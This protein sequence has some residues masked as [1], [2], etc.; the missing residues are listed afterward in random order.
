MTNES[1]VE[2]ALDRLRC[3]SWRQPKSKGEPMRAE[4]CREDAKLVE[5]ALLST[6]RETKKLELEVGVLRVANGELAEKVA[7]LTRAIEE[8]DEAMR[9]CIESMTATHYVLRTVRPDI[10]KI[11]GPDWQAVYEGMGEEFQTLQD[12]L[13][14]RGQEESRG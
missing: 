1:D 9:A 2:A 3:N 5:D 12:A 7:S 13:S 8:K 11:T 14:V 4:P 10:E 6:R